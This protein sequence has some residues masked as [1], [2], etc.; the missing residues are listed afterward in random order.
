MPVKKLKEFLDQEKIKYVSIIHST[1][2]T[3]QE[4]AASAHV[5]G[6]ELAKTIIVELDGEMAMAVLPANRKIVLQDL[7]EVTGSDEV[8][9][10]SEDEF[11]ER[12][13]GC[14]TGAMPP[15]GNL[16]GMEV[17][18]AESLTSNTELAF[19]A[20]S[21]TEVIKMSFQDFER[22]VQPKVMSFTT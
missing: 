2:Y 11:G 16:Y 12:F 4:V 13:P 5:T 14:E 9:F 10:A 1:A 19:N 6:R 7:R 15:F 20:G 3:A 22:L 8:K 18:L 17:Y 21:H